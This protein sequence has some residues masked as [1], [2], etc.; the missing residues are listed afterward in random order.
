MNQR[1]VALCICLLIAARVT[2]AIAAESPDVP[3][4][5]GH[6]S[7]I[8][9]F[10]ALPAPIPIE[11]LGRF[12]PGVPPATLA[13][14]AD[15]LIAERD[16]AWQV[17]DV[18]TPGA[19][20]PGRRFILG[21]R[22][23]DRVWAWYESGGIAHMFHVVVFEPGGGQPWRVSRHLADGSIATLCTRLETAATSVYDQFW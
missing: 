1:V 9:S 8:A 21:F 7:R 22:A 19:R 23:A 3:C 16:G 15:S 10:Q 13:M 11:M 18:A 5:P 6:A 4:L 14:S 17:T 2:A 20:L 12:A